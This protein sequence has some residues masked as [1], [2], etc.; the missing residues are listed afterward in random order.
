MKKAEAI[1]FEDAL[2]KLEI[3]AETLRKP[4]VSLEEA[5]EAFEMG[6]THYETCHKILDEAKQKIQVYGK[7]VNFNE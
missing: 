1:T 3:S 5:M 7:D 6:M 4:N 2:K